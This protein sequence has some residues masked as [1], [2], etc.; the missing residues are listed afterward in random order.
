MGIGSV[1]RTAAKTAGRREA[2]M[3]DKTTDIS[4]AAESWLAEFEAALATPR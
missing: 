4:I 2:R 3:L 1:R